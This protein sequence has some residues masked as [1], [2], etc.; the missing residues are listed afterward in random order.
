MLPQVRRLIVFLHRPTS[1]NRAKATSSCGLLVPGNRHSSKMGK[2]YVED[3]IDGWMSKGSRPGVNRNRIKIIVMI[4]KSRCVVVAELPPYLSR[5]QTQ[6]LRCPRHV[7][8]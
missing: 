3:R 1:G 2:V 5:H 7:R 4:N 6:K 8:I